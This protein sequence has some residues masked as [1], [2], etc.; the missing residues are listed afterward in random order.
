MNQSRSL[1]QHLIFW[2]LA[3][4]ATSGS[5][6]QAVSWG[7]HGMVLFGGK[8]SLYAAHL[9]MFHAPHD[10]QVV[11][12]I[13]IADAALDRAVKKRLDGKTALWTIAPEKFELERLGPQS[14]SPL[15]QFKADLVRGHFEQQGKT[16]YAGAAVVVDKVLLFQ[17]L[18]A[19]QKDS[20]R[21]D[22]LQLGD[23]RQR[24]LVK[25][26]DSRPDFDHIV[27]CDNKGG[28][29]LTA[30]PVSVPKQALQQPSD[31]ALAAALRQ[32]NGGTLPRCGTIYFSTDDLK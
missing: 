8:D 14:A 6:Q 13:H 4:L 20:I 25:R 21:A 32:A 23:A 22:Y 10:H 27:A 26:I 9:P 18:S 24:F 7:E 17:Q 1:R 28:G 12:Q 11:L 2:L 29:N 31:R 3:C 16:V 30:A 5:A 19:Q 15:T